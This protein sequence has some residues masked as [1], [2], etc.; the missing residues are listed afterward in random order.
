MSK[1]PTPKQKTSKKRTSER[2]AAWRTRARVQLIEKYQ[3]VECPNCKAPKLNQMV[4]PQCGQLNGKQV[5]DMN[6]KTDKITK[7]KA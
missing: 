2:H 4:C 7:I 5:I 1:K 3:V 6:K